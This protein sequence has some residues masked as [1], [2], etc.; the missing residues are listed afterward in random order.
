MSVAYEDYYAILGVKRGASGDEIQS[1][2]RRKARELHPD[3]NPDPEAEERFK[4][5]NE[6]YEVLKD[7]DKRRL[8]DQ[9]GSNWRAGQEFRAPPGF[10]GVRFHTGGAQGA[11]GFSDFFEAIFGQQAARA[12]GGAYGRGAGF[13]TRAQGP[14]MARPGRDR[15]AEITVSLEDVYRGVQKQITLK[16]A[17]RG[18]YGAPV[19]E[20]KSYNVRLPRGAKEGTVIRLAG[21]GEPGKGGGADGSLL[22]HVRLAEHAVFR[23]EDH[24]LVV[25]LRVTPW[26][27]ALGAKVPIDTLDGA[28][29]LSL[30]AGVRTGQRLRLRGKGLYTGDGE[31]RGMLYAEVA[32]EV[33]RDLSDEE[34]RLFEELAQ[35]S[36]FDPRSSG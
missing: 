13:D 33:P 4:K 7:A 30:P 24:D 28:L 19:P 18:P 26:E 14:P 29:R 22:L 15:E 20:T 16:F 34:R 31:E 11:A 23:V 32:I 10:E 8:Y 35:V 27:A 3:V 17:E 5:V 6:A 21:Q 1:A 36:S 25:S 9:L 2:Y 12:G